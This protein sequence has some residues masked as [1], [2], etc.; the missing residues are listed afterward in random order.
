[1]WSYLLGPWLVDFSIRLSGWQ[2][3]YSYW[4]NAPSK[5]KNIKK[6]NHSVFSKDIH[7]RVSVKNSQMIRVFENAIGKG[8]R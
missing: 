2:S 3:W 6:S 4:D 5:Q 1:M 8:N 7:Y